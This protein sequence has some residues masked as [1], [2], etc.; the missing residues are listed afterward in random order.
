[1]GAFPTGAA[2]G[3]GGNAAGVPVGG[4]GGASCDLYQ[5]SHAPDDASCPLTAGIGVVDPSVRANSSPAACTGRPHSG[6]NRAP[7]A[8]GC[9]HAGL[10]EPPARTIAT[11][12]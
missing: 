6:Q 4:G 3:G 11:T 9:P 5:E 8:T 1:M 2:S 7:G 10:T 12:P